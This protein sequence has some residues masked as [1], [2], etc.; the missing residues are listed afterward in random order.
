M[1]VAQHL[2]PLLGAALWFWIHRL[3]LQAG[4]PLQGTWLNLAQGWFLITT[5]LVYLA[6]HK[7]ARDHHSGADLRTIEVPAKRTRG[8][9]RPHSWV[10]GLDFPVSATIGASFALS[11]LL[12][13]SNHEL[14][15]ALA[16]VIGVL[17]V[18]K[19]YLYPTRWTSD[20]LGRIARGGRTRAQL[21]ELRAVLVQSD[22]LQVCLLDQQG[23]LIVCHQ[24]VSSKQRPHG[25]ALRDVEGV[26][27]EIHEALGLPL[28]E[29]LGHYEV[30]RLDGDWGLM[31]SKVR[32]VT[33]LAT[34]G[35]AFL[36]CTP[37]LAGLHLFG[38]GLA[39]DKLSGH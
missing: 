13:S 4:V 8:Q 16:A 11:F 25:Q 3:W 14:G 5:M 1:F 33:S 9:A 19:Y 35:F 20:E 31:G 32:P 37:V 39:L 12:L 29:G 34:I 22:A 7:M 24:D 23:R 38:F 30:Q 17:A 15:S 18:V 10:A 28:V 26:A 2:L 27:R 36:T 6:Y 21:S